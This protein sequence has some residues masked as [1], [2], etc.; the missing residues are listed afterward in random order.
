MRANRLASIS[1]VAC[2]AVMCSALSAQTGGAAAASQGSA[3]I[4]T[5]II[6]YRALGKIAGDL[7]AR[8]ATDICKG[9]ACSGGSTRAVL[10]ADTNSLTELAGYRSF[11]QTVGLLEQQYGALTPGLHPRGFGDAT[12]GA[13]SLLGAIRSSATYTNQNFQPAAQSF[14]T[15]LNVNLKHAGIELR[16][17]ASPGDQTAALDFVQK[18]LGG[19]FNAQKQVDAKARAAVDAQF[20]SFLASLGAASADG[21]VL[22]AA[23]KGRALSETLGQDY[24]LLT[25]S[26]DAAGGDT[27]VTHYGLYEIF[28]PTP[29]PAYN[30]GAVVSFT[31][32]D[33]A[34]NLIDGDVL[35]GM[36]RFMKLKSPSL[37]GAD[38]VVDPAK[39]TSMIGK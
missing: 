38:R 8:L 22:I 34:G 28:F 7:A 2:V 23:I 11:E 5:Q 29:A 33:R 24:A 18:E 25:V 26:V 30:G 19:V 27:K 35:A 32:N 3:P 14:I 4:E 39:P 12:L 1:A 15:L 9:S 16:T 17:S 10:L 13:G 6:A 20:T 36:Y 21:T 37:Q 31:L